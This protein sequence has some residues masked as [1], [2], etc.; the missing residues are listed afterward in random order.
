MMQICQPYRSINLGLVGHVVTP[1]KAW[2]VG[3]SC[4]SRCCT[5]CTWY[6]QQCMRSTKHLFC[7]H[8]SY[9]T[10]VPAQTHIDS[11]QISR[12]CRRLHCIQDRTIYQ[13]QMA[14]VAVVLL[15]ELSHE[16]EWGTADCC[17]LLHLHQG[18]QA[19]QVLV[20]YG[21]RT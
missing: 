21:I 4:S 20:S 9:T 10:C 17:I 2:H 18:C 6:V 7:Y 12:A 11:Q 3:C 13:S 14:V 16:K 15:A 5:V 8:T 19:H 1:K